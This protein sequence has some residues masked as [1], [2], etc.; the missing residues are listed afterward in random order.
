MIL[1]IVTIFL[2]SFL[3]VLFPT[4][5]RKVNAVTSLFIV[6][7]LALYAGLREG[8]KFNDYEM[9]VQAW[10]RLTYAENQIEVSYIFIRNILRYDLGF[11]SVSIFMFYAFLGVATKV[12]AIKKISNL[13]YLS[14]L[15]Y[16]SH[17]FILHELTQ[18][19]A[20]VAAGFVLLAIVPLYGRNLKYFLLLMLIA[21][22]FHYSAVIILPL[23]YLRTHR[24][25]Q[26][27]YYLLPVGYVLYFI[28]FNF[29]Q[30]IPIPYVQTKLDAY[31]ELSRK[32]VSGF[33]T[34]N[35]FNAVFL[36][37]VAL[38]YLIMTLRERISVHNKYFFLL[39]RIE[40]FSLFALP[41]LAVIPAIAYRVHEFLGI[42]EVVLFPMLVYAFR[43]RY[44]GYIIVTGLA[45]ALFCIN[46]FYNKLILP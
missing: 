14:I 40:A 23:W 3:L 26:Y 20:G 2:I 41:A 32:G 39:L 12:I 34:I 9:Y 24:R 10:N 30:N 19:R 27:L 5:L 46:I 21:T 43:I 18:I 15:I 33:D 8:R 6:V 38:F 11:S 22:L 44:V 16:I 35:V 13:F 25:V 29:M 37:K 28:G 7:V 1:G 4:R 42:V 36:V 31:R 45:V 17:F